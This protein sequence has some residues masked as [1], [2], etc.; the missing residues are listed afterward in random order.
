[1]PERVGET[2]VVMVRCMLADNGLPMFL[3]GE[4]MFKVAYV[5][6]RAP[7]SALNM[8]SPYK[9]LKGTEIDYRFFASSGRGPLCTLRDAPKSSHSRQLKDEWWGTAATATA[10][11]C[12]QSGHPMHHGKQERRLYRDAVAPT[13]ATFREVNF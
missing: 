6:I 4:L 1:M 11:S 2:L 13:S 10:I 9:M 7:Y 8:Q 12:V 5:G 3:W